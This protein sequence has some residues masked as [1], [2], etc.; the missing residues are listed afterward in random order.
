MCP[1]R[2]TPKPFCSEGVYI[3][4]IGNVKVFNEKRQVTAFNVRPIDDFNE[5]THHA[6]ESIYCHLKA[7]KGA[8]SAGAGGMGST[9]SVLL[10]AFVLLATIGLAAASSS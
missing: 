7:T 1:V 3:R 8:A 9:V 4:V 5:V 10:C 6:M 2:P